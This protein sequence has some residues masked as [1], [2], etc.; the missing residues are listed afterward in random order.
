MGYTNG[1]VAQL[2]EHIP[3]E[4]GVV[5][6]I[7]TGSTKLLINTIMKLQ[8]LLENDGRAGYRKGKPLSSETSEP[9]VTI[10]RAQPVTYL[11][12]EDGSYITRSQ[13][14]AKDHAVSSANYEDEPFHVVRAIVETKYVF[15]ADNPGEYIYG[16]PPKKGKPIFVA[17]PG[18]DFDEA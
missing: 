16:G 2:V 3:E 12:F 7:P 13:K 11:N 4:D 14:F 10:Y 15:N 5:G 8:K 1:T 6:S 9:Y 18:D 17:N